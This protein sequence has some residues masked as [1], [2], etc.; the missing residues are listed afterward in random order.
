MNTTSN[1][2]TK[3]QWHSPGGISFFMLCIFFLFP[4][5]G[6]A[7]ISPGELA[8]PHAFLE[9]ITNCTKCH[10]LG[11]G[12]SNN[13]C[14][15]CH[16][17]IGVRLQKKRGFHH[18]ISKSEKKECYVCHADHAGRSFELI[19]WPDG[20]DS[21][22]HKLAGFILRGRHAQL[23]CRDCHKPEFIKEN[24]RKYQPEIDLKRTFLG[25]QKSC[26]SC[27]IDEHGAQLADD[28]L[29]CHTQKAWKPASKF[30]H[31]R[32]KFTLTG[33]HR[34][35]D[36]A[37]CHPVIKKEIP[38]GS[39]RVGSMKFTGL[40]FAT[41]ASCHEDIH[42]GKFGADCQS[43]HNTKDWRRS[44]RKN[45]NHARTNFPL[46]GK[47]KKVNCSSCHKSGSVLKPLR[48]ENCS[49]CHNDVHAGKFGAD[50]QRC[51]TENGWKQVRKGTF[52]H[53]LTDFPLRGLHQNVACAACHKPGAKDRKMA[54]TL[55]SDCHQD[56]HLGQFSR[57]GKAA[58]CEKC[59][60]ESGFLPS[61]FGID[62]H[63]QTDFQLA[64]SHLAIPCTAC[65][66]MAKTKTGKKVRR[67]IFKNTNCSGCHKD[68]HFGQFIR[69][70]P[71]K[72][73][74]NCHVPKSWIEL[75]F[76]H[77]RD[78]RYKLEGKHVGVGCDECHKQVKVKQY[79]FTR[80]RP[81]DTSCETCHLSRPK[82]EVK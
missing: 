36:C 46:K 68:I 4:Q 45:F 64:G 30:D 57:N 77:N 44:S 27:H 28:C 49:S 40:Q 21:F 26:I 52:D 6:S 17:E 35:V 29:Q 63:A 32:S 66:Q 51:H 43:C 24:L 72:K 14:L 47:H 81:I 13:K 60:N 1:P 20:R 53:N 58:R 33:K 16:K 67:F 80:Y 74:E 59:H 34:S 56:V 8:E 39:G 37:Q 38:V 70:K 23:D 2:R 50:C 61:N 82:T 41:C 71:V 25:L 18:T 62:E 31:N 78:S 79:I 42:R 54:H 7:Q 73:C 9:G 55:C 48:F 19:R 69:S 5:Y 15:S 10:D 22:D 65:H 12:L 76:L 3:Q 75:V 11:K